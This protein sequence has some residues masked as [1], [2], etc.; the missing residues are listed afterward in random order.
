MQKIAILGLVGLEPVLFDRY[1]LQILEISHRLVD[2]F[3]CKFT[4]RLL[5]SM[6][7]IYELRESDRLFADLHQLAAGIVGSGVT[8]IE[9]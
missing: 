5:C 3:N 7:A 4:I 8:H 9:E 1:K 6:H 2:K